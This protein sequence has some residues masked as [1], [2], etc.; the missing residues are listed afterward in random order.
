M[1]R[2]G[3]LAFSLTMLCA[4]RAF[5][6]PTP[7]LTEPGDMTLTWTAPDGCPTSEAVR[8]QIEKN[9]TT[10]KFNHA[11]VDANVTE[12]GPHRWSVHLRT[13]V[14][15]ARGDRT[16]EADSCAALAD[17]TALVVALA[18]NPLHD[19]ASTPIT[20]VAPSPS[21]TEPA[22]SP[23]N[24]TPP[25]IE[26][27]SNVSG[28]IA[29]T[30][31]GA[32]GMLPNV[33]AAPG[34][35]IGATSE[36]LRAEVSGNIWFTQNAAPAGAPDAPLQLLD[37]DARVCWR[38][39]FHSLELAPCAGIGY[40]NLSAPDQSGATWWTM[41]RF[42]GI[43]TWTIVQPFAIR[44]LLGAAV[45]LE[46]DF[47]DIYQNDDGSTKMLRPTV[48]SAQAAIGVETHFP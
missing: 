44:A 12:I 4:S 25:P 36:H 15:D 43:A 16:I 46:R 30:L 13:N 37:L 40:A 6:Q 19:D 3:A 33:G 9:V 29:L 18:I 11:D 38:F 26:P 45:P 14:D 10:T 42:D 21:I 32:Y 8:S 48:I 1:R 2:V 24:F 27:S 34:L 41:A 39:L 7:R 35:T 17:A 31:M 47:V 20:P 23:T 5:A 22:E 28:I